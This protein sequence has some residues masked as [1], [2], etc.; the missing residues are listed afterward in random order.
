LGDDGLSLADG[1]RRPRSGA[2]R[3]DRRWALVWE[4]I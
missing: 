2:R 4:A 1:A 3:V